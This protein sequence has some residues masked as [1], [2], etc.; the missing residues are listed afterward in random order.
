MNLFWHEVFIGKCISAHLDDLFLRHVPIYSFRAFLSCWN[1]GLLI[2]IIRQ[3]VLSRITLLIL[4]A[5]IEKPGK[6]H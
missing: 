6:D 3:F 2:A 1:K 5:P 4:S